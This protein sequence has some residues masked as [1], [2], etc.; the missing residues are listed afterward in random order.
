MHMHNKMGEAQKAMFSWKG[1]TVLSFSRLSALCGTFE[2]KNFKY[3]WS[4]VRE[5]QA[6]LTELRGNKNTH[7]LF[8]RETHSSIDNEAEWGMGW[9]ML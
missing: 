5:R 8:L 4:R 6:V 1:F 3:Q 9:R 2:D 7:V